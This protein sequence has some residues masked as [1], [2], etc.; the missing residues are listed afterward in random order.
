MIARIYFVGYAGR[1]TEALAY[2][3]SG[4]GSGRNERGVILNTQALFI[5]PANINDYLIMI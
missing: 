5:I 4:L 1:A 2:R 3:R